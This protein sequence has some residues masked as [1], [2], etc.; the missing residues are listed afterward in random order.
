M[1]V[2][3]LL[4]LSSKTDVGEENFDFGS[5]S[6]KRNCLIENKITNYNSLMDRF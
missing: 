4:I 6:L 1:A 3:T 5:N 2:I